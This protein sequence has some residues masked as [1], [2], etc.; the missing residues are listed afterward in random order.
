MFI[1][2]IGDSVVHCN[3]LFFQQ[4]IK[5]NIHFTRFHQMFSYFVL[6]CCLAQKSMRFDLRTLSLMR[7]GLICDIV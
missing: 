5:D 3:Q 6:L 7:N 4:K 2:L 1:L